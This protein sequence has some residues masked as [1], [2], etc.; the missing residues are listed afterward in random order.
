MNG[1]RDTTRNFGAVNAMTLD[2]KLTAAT[3]P[4]GMQLGE[5]RPIAYFDKHMD[6]IRVVTHDRSITEHRINEHFTVFEPNHKTSFDPQ[7]VGFSIKGVRRLFK[8]T[9]LSLESSYSLAS[10]IDEIVK[11]RPGS[12]MAESLRIIFLNYQSQGDLKIDM[13]AARAA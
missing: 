9:G 6:C 13:T 7:Y 4:D 5:F 3:I 1:T 2:Y 11:R 10:L 12:L 8:E